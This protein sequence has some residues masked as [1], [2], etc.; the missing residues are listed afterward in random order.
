MTVADYGYD[1]TPVPGAG[2]C[3]ARVLGTWGDY[4]RILCDAGEGIAR[5]KASAF[6][7]KPDAVIP[8]TGDFVVLKWNPH[9]ESR[10]LAT[11]PRHSKFERAA[12]GSE[13]RRAQTI[14]VNFDTLF[15]LT[16]ANQNFNVRRLERFLSLGRASGAP[17]VVLL[18]KCDLVDAAERDRL[19]AEARAHAGDVEVLPISS[20]TGDGLDALAPYVQP[21]RTLAFIGSSGV[22]KSS[23][24][25]ALAGDELMPTLEIRE[26]DAKGRHTTTEREL[27]RLPCGALVIDTPGMREIGMWEA[28]EGIADA[29]TD[30]ES[31]FAHCRFSD[32]RHDTEPGC[33]VKAALA[34]GSLAE[35][36]WLAYL[37]L[38]AEAAQAETKHGRNESTHRYRK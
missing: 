2:T 36:R 8:T 18:T 15:F 25:N 14:A 22:G 13:G 6:H 20:L 21:R 11:L 23:L 37:R 34:D 10:I 33:A 29:F 17:V 7:G 30:V 9:G 24:I 28:D 26:W 35:D 5:K 12:A 1:G 27:V 38:K 19:L 16:S 32:C 31:L 3:P 4:Y